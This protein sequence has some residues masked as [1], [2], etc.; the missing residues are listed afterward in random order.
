M[1]CQ[2][3]AWLAQGRGTLPQSGL[4]RPV[5][6]VASL[7]T[8]VE[9]APMTEDRTHRGS[10]T[11]YP[12]GTTDIPREFLSEEYRQSSSGSMTSPGTIKSPQARRNLQK[13]SMK[14]VRML[15]PKGF[16][17]DT[18]PENKNKGRRRSCLKQRRESK[19]RCVHFKTPESSPILFP[20]I[21]RGVGMDGG[22]SKKVELEFGSSREQDDR[23][24]TIS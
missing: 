22:S 14:S 21:E 5:T 17:S 7:G 3:H 12:Q 23:C 2:L 13:H 4:P 11:P 9:N 15:S 16:A 18:V 6:C 20:E 24:I 8:S 19:R 10:R 1:I